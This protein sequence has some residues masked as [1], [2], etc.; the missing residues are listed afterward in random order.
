VFSFVA[1]ERGLNDDNTELSRVE[2]P[3]V[4]GLKK[5]MVWMDRGE[6]LLAGSWTVHVGVEKS[7]G[8]FKYF[9]SIMDSENLY[10]IRSDFY[11]LLLI[12]TTKSTPY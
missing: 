10:L 6:G 5:R 3:G 11:P 2:F 8:L 12:I 9:S 4:D 1:F 7:Q